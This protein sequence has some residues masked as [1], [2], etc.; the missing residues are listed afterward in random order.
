MT[1]R[2]LS[3]LQVEFSY[4]DQINVTTLKEF[5]KENIDHEYIDYMKIDVEGHEKDVLEG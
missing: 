3:F 4:E 5:W 2:D 1:K